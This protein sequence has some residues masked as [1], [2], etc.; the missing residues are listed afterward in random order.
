MMLLLPASVALAMFGSGLRLPKHA[1]GKVALLPL[2]VLLFATIIGAP[3]LA[4]LLGSLFG[5]DTTMTAALLVIASC[6]VGVTASVWCGLARGSVVHTLLATI[7]S[8]ALAPIS[9]SFWF[10]LLP[11]GLSVSE[12]A[13]AA[14]LGQMVLAIGALTGLPLFLGIWINRRRPVSTAIGEWCKTI[15][16]LGVL[17]SFALVIWDQRAVMATAVSFLPAIVAMNA[18]MA[19]IGLIIGIPLRGALVVRRAMMFGVLTRQEETGLLVATTMLGMPLLAVPL[20]ANAV[21]ATAMALC[22]IALFRVVGS[23]ASESNP[24]ENNDPQPA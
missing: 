21:I 1:L 4:L 24:K 16:A 15:G 6:P 10:N 18:G 11:G 8:T 5:G 13:L 7:L 12:T 9:I 17:A 19:V 22:L 20:L 3:A 2:G 23:L 14:S